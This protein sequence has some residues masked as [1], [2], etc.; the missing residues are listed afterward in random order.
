MFIPFVAITDDQQAEELIQQIKQAEAERDRLIN[1][2][3]DQIAYY[4]GKITGYNIKHENDI[5]SAM[6]LLGEYCR[7]KANR[8]TKTLISYY[9]PSGK[10]QWKQ[11]DGKIT[12]DD[13]TLLEWLKTN[14]L[15]YVKIEEKPDWESLKKNAI[16]VGDHYVTLDGEIIEGVVVEPQDEIFEVK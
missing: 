8:Q 6:A 14:N 13:K 2:C 5:S 15:P 10:L 1:C 16:S 3:Q 12:R 11:R 9:L 7:Q 4:Q